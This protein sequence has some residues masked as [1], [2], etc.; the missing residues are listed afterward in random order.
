M[1]HFAKLFFVLTDWLSPSESKNKFKCTQLSLSLKDLQHEPPRAAGGWERSGSF[2]RKNV[3]SCVLWQWKCVF[4]NWGYLVST[5]DA[6]NHRQFAQTLSDWELTVFC[7]LCELQSHLAV[8]L[9]H[10]PLLKKQGEKCRTICYI[11]SK[12]LLQTVC[13][14][15]DM[16]LWSLS[17]W[18]LR[19]LP[20]FLYR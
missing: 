20:C 3:H 18:L 9:L 1:N 7:K 10:L 4:R 15:S 5:G 8:H 19:L 11:Y 6:T 14:Y 13:S 12:K 17:S 2:K 16:L